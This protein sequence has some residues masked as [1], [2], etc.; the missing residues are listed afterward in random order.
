MTVMTYSKWM[1]DAGRKAKPGEKCNFAKM[2][3]KAAAREAE[4]GQ[5]PSA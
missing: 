4:A 3:A 2:Q 1:L 5:Q